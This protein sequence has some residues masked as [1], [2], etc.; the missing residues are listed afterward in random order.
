[1]AE[2]VP[3]LELQ[4]QNGAQTK[5]D[6]SR[7][8]ESIRALDPNE[9]IVEHTLHFV[10]ATTLLSRDHCL[11]IHVNCAH[12]QD[13]IET[14]RRMQEQMAEMMSQLSSGMMN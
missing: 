8:D 11:L 5:L 1:M 13:A 14:L 10:N 7:P 9:K 12:Q 3:C 2:N 4:L 6:F